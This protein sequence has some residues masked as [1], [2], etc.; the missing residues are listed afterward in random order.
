MQRFWVGRRVSRLGYLGGLGV[1]L[2]SLA[3][4]RGPGPE[5]NTERISRSLLIP[6][7]LS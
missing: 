3:A 7:F 5:R 6:I 1:L 2:C 4:N